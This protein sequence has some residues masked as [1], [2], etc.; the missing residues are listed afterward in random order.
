VRS[1]TR[2]ARLA[3]SNISLELGDY[4]AAIE[5]L[6]QVLDEFP[7]DIGAS[8]DLGYLWVD[9]NE[10]LQR[11]LKLIQRAVEAEPERA[12]YRDSLGWAY[13]RM[14]R[15]EE[16]VVELSKAAAGE[17]EGTILDHLGDAL[18]EA[19]KKDDAIAAWKRAA[20]AFQKAGETRKWEGVQKKIAATDP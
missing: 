11:A 16:A 15:Y 10:H 7:E 14:G 8:N 13:Y 20:A 18:N 19:G 1:V 2:E 9:H 5:W 12:A 17:P 6:E 4:P 3:L